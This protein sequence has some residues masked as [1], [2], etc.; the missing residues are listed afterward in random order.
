MTLGKSC[1]LQTSGQRRTAR[2]VP[3]ECSPRAAPHRAGGR[4]RPD[5]APCGWRHFRG[6]RSAPDSRG[7]A[8]GRPR[9]GRAP[10]LW[11]RWFAGT[12]GKTARLPHGL[13][14]PP[15]RAIPAPAWTAGPGPGILSGAFAALKTGASLRLP[16]PRVRD[17]N[18]SPSGRRGRACA[19]RF[20][21]RAR[22]VPTA[23]TPGPAPRGTMK[24]PALTLTFPLVWREGPA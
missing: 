3:D 14:R 24:I 13:L 23:R 6:D 10:A 11:P 20:G 2:G 9:Q 17:A 12:E 8:V 16:C 7:S 5:A 1:H 18:R 19:P 15:A 22:A 4:R 21:P